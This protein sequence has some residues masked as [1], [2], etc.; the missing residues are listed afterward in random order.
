MN[1]DTIAA[2]A[3]PVGVGGIGVIR[4]SGA[5]S[6]EILERLHDRGLEAATH[7][8]TMA[9]GRILDGGTV[10][11]QGLAVF[12]PNPRSYTGEDTAELQLHGGSTIMNSVLQATLR[13]GA[14]LA[15][16]GEFTQR[17]FLNGKL[18]LAQA[19]AVA[20][21]ITADSTAA[22]RLAQT[23]LGGELSRRVDDLR[24]QIVGIIAELSAWLDFGDEDIGDVD[25]KDLVARVEH[26][27]SILADWIA[28]SKQGRV[29]REGIVAAIVGLPN[30]GKSSLMNALVGYERAIVTD[31]AGTTRDTLE[32][33][34]EVDGVAVRLVDTA[35]MVQTTNRVEG[36]GVERAIKAA[37]SADIILVASHPGQKPADLADQIAALGKV[38]APIVAVQTQIDAHRGDVSWPFTPLTTIKTSAITGEGLSELRKV[39]SQAI[40]I[41]SSAEVPLVANIRHIEV[42]NEAYS[43]LTGALEAIDQEAPYDIVV[44][45]LQ[46]SAESLAGITGV[47]VNQEVINA[48]FSNF[49]IGK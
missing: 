44:G 10:L 17:A 16:P 3:T 22:L 15:A 43:L 42:L 28:Q 4:I 21:V 9:L 41:G 18:D 7:P 13:A 8:R 27:R 25:R 40:L 34:I 11:D 46:L 32:E 2:I 12:M 5:K 37:H 24:A 30:A 31:I 19:E 39:I 23:Q 36:I 47:G 48:I 6:R 29:M 45:Q 1:Q 49:C 35:G 38:M 26:I 20:D 14:R 33:V